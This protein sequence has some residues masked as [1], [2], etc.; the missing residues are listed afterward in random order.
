ME[1]KEAFIETLFERAEQ[2]C[3]TYYE[4]GKLKIVD[5]VADLSSTFIS[6]GG[7]A[8]VFLVPLK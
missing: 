8:L 6:R 2:Y 7:T 1:D 4:L 3:N 5:K